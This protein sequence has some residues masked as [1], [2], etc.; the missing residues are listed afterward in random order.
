MPEPSRIVD[1]RF[2]QRACSLCFLLH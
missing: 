2:I 1:A